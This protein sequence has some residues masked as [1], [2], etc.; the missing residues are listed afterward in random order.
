MFLIKRLKQVISDRWPSK[1]NIELKNT[2]DTLTILGDRPSKSVLISWRILLKAVLA[3]RFREN[4]CDMI[5]NHRAPSP[6]RG[7]LSDY[8]MGLSDTLIL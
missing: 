1:C 8:C 3:E 5:T 4:T 6:L 2:C 7:P